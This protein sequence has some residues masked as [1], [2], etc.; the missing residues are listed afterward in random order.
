MRIFPGWLDGTARHTFAALA[1]LASITGLTFADSMYLTNGGQ[2]FSFV[3]E[4]TTTG[5][6]LG[7]FTNSL[8]N[9]AGIAQDFSGN[10]YVVN[11]GNSTVVKFLAD[12]TPVAPNPFI[13]SHLRAAQTIAIDK[14]GNFYVSEGG[15]TVEKFNSAGVWQRQFA[16]SGAGYSISNA[17]GLWV[18]AQDTL[19]IADSSANNQV[20]L[21]N[22]N[23][24]AY[25]NKINTNLSLPHGVI[26]D[27]SGY[28][29][30]SNA[31]ANNVAKFNPDLS[32]NSFITGGMSFPIGLGLDATGNL[33]VANNQNNTLTKYDSSGA[34][35]ATIS[36][37]NNSIVGARWIA[38]QPYAVPEP[39]TYAMA[40]AGLACGGYLVRRR[41][42]RA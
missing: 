8:N 40:L 14:S 16:A 38:F 21:L 27:A 28:L 35:T 42:K 1:L 36:S 32:F 20:V 19:Y 18:D 9:P 12:G 41:R 4:F 6:Y 10:Y 25:I 11:A 5:T 26:K 22:A 23:T 13:T 15:G 33:F 37:V 31:S 7:Q 29:Y 30:V 34:L 2:A 39:S 17:Q 24:G 3:S